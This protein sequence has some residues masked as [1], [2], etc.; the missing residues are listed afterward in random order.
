V[1]DQTSGRTAANSIDDE[2]IGNAFYVSPLLKY[3]WSEKT[4]I[5]SSVTFAQLMTNPTNSK[6]FNRALGF[7]W[8]LMLGHKFRQNMLWLNQ[9][10]F[11]FPGQAFA[12]GVS[13]FGTSNTFGLA[14]KIA[15]TF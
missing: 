14:S 15:V 6:D 4:E 1:K 3:L 5:S 2:A 13:G 9:V 11:L 7:E 8:D 12:D 10:G